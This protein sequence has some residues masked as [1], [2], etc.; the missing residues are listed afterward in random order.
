M[1]SGAITEHGRP[2][3]GP[4][5]STTRGGPPSPSCAGEKPRLDP[6]K[7]LPDMWGCHTHAGH[8][9]PRHPPPHHQPPRKSG[10]RS[11]PVHT[12]ETGLPGRCPHAQ[13]PGRQG[14][15]PE[16]PAPRHLQTP[17]P[18]L[19]PLLTIPL[20]PPNCWASSLGPWA[21]PPL[22]RQ[23]GSRPGPLIHRQSP[24]ANHPA[25]RSSSGC[26]LQWPRLII[27]GNQASTMFLGFQLGL[28]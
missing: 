24:G 5:A 13:D 7:C 14:L 21:P 12:P 11:R 16:R 3:A 9:Q 23:R 15:H 17:A 26:L 27:H 22:P 25:G 2:W 6:R 10:R 19:R 20:Q 18:G 28:D 8:F 4:P 1:S